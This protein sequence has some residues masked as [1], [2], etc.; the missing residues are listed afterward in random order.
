MVPV[1]MS[2]V[3][4]QLK[5]LLLI[6]IKYDKIEQYEDEYRLTDMKEA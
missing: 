3:Y 6:K 4:F 2:L 5:N 1:N